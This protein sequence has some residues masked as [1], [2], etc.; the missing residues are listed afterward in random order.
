MGPVKAVQKVHIDRYSEING[1]EI[2]YIDTTDYFKGWKTVFAK[3]GDSILFKDLDFGKR[4]PKS[5]IFRIKGDPASTADIHLSAGDAS[6]ILRIDVTPEW[7]E[8]KIRMP[9]KITGMQ[10]LKVVLA[11]GSCIEIDWITFK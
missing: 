1:A 2:Q 6:M 11:Q 10:D 3:E 7:S 4:A 5:V 9:K 8:V